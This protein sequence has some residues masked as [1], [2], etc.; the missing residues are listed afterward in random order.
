[1]FSLVVQYEVLNS[2]L[3]LKLPFIFQY[4]CEIS[5]PARC[6]LHPS[7]PTGTSS[8]PTFTHYLCFS[9]TARSKL[10]GPSSVSS[11]F[12]LATEKLW[13]GAV[14]AIFSNCQ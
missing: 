1:M 4:L 6:P 3:P 2:L 13:D 9:I 5:P 8:I 7:P 10:A 12:K 14:H 11:N